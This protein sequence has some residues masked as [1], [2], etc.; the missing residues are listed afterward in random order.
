MEQAVLLTGLQA[1]LFVQDDTVIL[2]HA[3]QCRK[4]MS[5]GVAITNGFYENR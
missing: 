3:V 1:I 2:R 4:I 5:F